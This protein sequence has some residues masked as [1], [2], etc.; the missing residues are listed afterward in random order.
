MQ[1]HRAE[2]GD[3]GVRPLPHAHRPQ[4]SAHPV[5]ALEEGHTAAP[6]MS[7]GF[8]LTGELFGQETAS[9][10]GSDYRRVE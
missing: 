5:R 9:D 4:P 10:S 3:R 8:P 7:G 6:G 1:P 2:V